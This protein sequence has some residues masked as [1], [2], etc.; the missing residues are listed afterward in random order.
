MTSFAEVDQITKE[1]QWGDEDMAYL[2]TIFIMD[3]NLGEEYVKYLRNES[4]YDKSLEGVE[5]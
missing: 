2:A 5:Q 4:S 3:A 1:Q